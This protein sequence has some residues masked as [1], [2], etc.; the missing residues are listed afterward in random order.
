MSKMYSL[1]GEFNWND[2]EERITPRMDNFLRSVAKVEFPKFDVLR[3]RFTANLV[4]YIELMVFHRGQESN[5]ANDY[6]VDCEAEI[7]VLECAGLIQSDWIK[8]YR[9][10][11]QYILFDEL[12]RCGIGKVEG[13]F[14]DI[15][16]EA[17]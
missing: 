4:S 12:R 3:D 14:V 17:E 1:F 7:G 2:T 8:H 5:V 9:A 15:D 10:M 6:A 16:E 11:V 13:W